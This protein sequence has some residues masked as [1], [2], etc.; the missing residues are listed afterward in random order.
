MFLAYYSLFMIQILYYLNQTQG[1][2]GLGCL[3]N[4]SCVLGRAVEHYSFASFV[5]L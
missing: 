2:G 4:L 5:C 1:L 3:L